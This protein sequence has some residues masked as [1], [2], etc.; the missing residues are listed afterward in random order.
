MSAQLTHPKNKTVR[1]IFVAA[2]RMN[3][4]KTTTCLG[5]YTTLQQRLGNIGF[6]K[7]VGQRFVRI[8]DFLV[9]EDSV[10]LDTIYDLQTPLETMSPVTIDRTFSRRYLQDPERLHPQ[11]VD[12]VCRSFDQASDNKQFT[13]IEGT[14]HAGVGSVFDLSN[15]KTA[16]ILRSNVVLVA[17]GGIG[18][19]IDEI[20]L[21]QALFQQFGIPIVGVILNK[22]RA[23]KVEMVEEF[24]RIALK[25]MGIPL[26]G[27]MP[28][29]NI[30]ASPSLDQIVEET[31]ARW[32]NGEEWARNNRIRRVVIG[33][34]S[35]QSLL[36]N[37]GEGILVITAGDQEDILLAAIA[38]AQMDGRGSL[39]GIIMTR[40][41][42]PGKRILELLRKTQIPVAITDK[43]SY[44][45]TSLIHNMSV[46]TRPEDEDKIPLIQKMI[47]QHIDIDT[48]LD[49][50]SPLA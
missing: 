3:H 36:N 1:R 50:C 8:K 23:D 15:A 21:N 25:R 31:A 38:K 11:L 5:L 14:G 22:V 33:A 4:G 9:D 29:E 20:T 32:I 39:A 7:P 34:M 42:E 49:H 40:A 28:E 26:L 47:Q 43:G 16:H 18:K 27:V 10:L 41:I 48:L 24:S 30:L 37:L 13:L 17:E 35:A 45:V 19:S 2:T 46:K 44:L 6:I 12:K